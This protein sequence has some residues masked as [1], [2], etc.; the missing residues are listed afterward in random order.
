MGLDTYEVDCASADSVSIINAPDAY[1]KD[2]SAVLLE[3]LDQY[4]TSKAV[5]TLSFR[6]LVS[7]I[8]GGER[9]T[10]Y[11]HPYPAKL[12]PQIAY[13]FLA[14]QDF[15][16]KRLRVLDPFGG[17]GT[18]ALETILSGNEA[19]YSDANPLAR[20]IAKAKTTRIDTSKLRSELFRIEKAYIK[21]RASKK[22]DVVNIEK[23]FSS[24]TT[25]QLVRLKSSI[26][27][28]KCEDTR[29]FYLVVFSAVVRKVSNADPRLSVPVSRKNLDTT[30][31]VD[32]FKT[33]WQQ[34]ES[35]IARMSELTKLGA[36]SSH[37]RDVGFDARS[38]KSPKS[39]GGFL[40]S[41]LESKSIDLII[42]S[43]P[44]AGAQKYIRAS[45]LSLGWL[46]LAGSSGLKDL[47]NKNIGR[48]HLPKSIWASSFSTSVEAAN[49]VIE[50]VRIVNPLRAAIAATYLN[51]MEQCFQEMSRVLTDNGHLVLV[52]GNN[53]VCGQKFLSSEYLTSIAE[54][55]GLV[56]I[57]KAVD[58]I[59]SRGLMTKRN[60]TAGVISLEW[61]IMFRKN[62]SKDVYGY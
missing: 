33:F 60:K 8:K 56:P 61:V 51:E 40:S 42:T 7:W 38:L 32:V 22:P 57:F 27:S 39:W 12:L 2:T 49:E 14:A 30:S 52:I 44:Y 17:S 10:H 45:S 23:W 6:S 15:F 1:G 58:E 5:Q 20:C 34:A 48:E 29:D 46:G 28:C 36:H 31:A 4:Q 62:L 19:F 13:F 37:V 16:G 24:E 11:I 21:S 55:Y 54:N 3:M 25:K 50:R 47:E 41:P 18:V 26:N 53:E 43:P 35:N 9:A 59:K